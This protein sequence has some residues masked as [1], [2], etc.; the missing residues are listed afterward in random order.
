MKKT[1][2]HRTADKMKE[3]NNLAC[4]NINHT[5]T[6]TRILNTVKSQIECFR[7]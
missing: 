6:T 7:V 1:P 3:Y 5:E 2:L 4:E